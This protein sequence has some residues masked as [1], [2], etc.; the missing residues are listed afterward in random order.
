M[1][2]EILLNRTEM[3]GIL[4]ELGKIVNEFMYT[5]APKCEALTTK[6]YYKKG[7]AMDTMGS[8][9]Q[10]ILKTNDLGQLYTSSLMAVLD[11][12]DKMSQQDKELAALLSELVPE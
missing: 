3:E 12:L 1:P 9:N 6:E 7:K 11:I 10:A 5:I 8:Y 2:E 4:D